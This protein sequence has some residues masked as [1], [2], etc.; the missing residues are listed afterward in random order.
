MERKSGNLKHLPTLHLCEACE[1]VVGTLPVHRHR[2]LAPSGPLYHV[3]VSARRLLAFA[4]GDG[5]AMGEPI[6]AASRCSVQ[7]G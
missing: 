5:M 2:A 4:E 3:A 7:S 6:M 1:H